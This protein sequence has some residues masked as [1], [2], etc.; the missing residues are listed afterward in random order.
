VAILY[1]PYL[2]LV[3]KWQASI[4]HPS[5]T[6]SLREVF[7]PRHYAQ[8]VYRFAGG[9]FI[10]LLATATVVCA[11][12]RK[13]KLIWLSLALFFGQ[14]AFVHAFLHGRTAFNLRY[15]MPAFP[16]FCLWLALGAE[17]LL[18]RAERMAW[19]VMPAVLLA[20]DVLVA[21]SFVTGLRE[22]TPRLKWRKLYTAVEELPGKK[23]VFFDVGWVGQPFAY[24]ARKDPHVVP[25]LEQ[26]RGWFTG[27]SPLDRAYVEE[28][29]SRMKAD[30]NCFLYVITIERAE[31][32]GPYPSA[33]VPAMKDLSYREALHLEH[34]DDGGDSWDVH[35]FCKVVSAQ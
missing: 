31:A 29:I 18:S 30:T 28:N 11:V 7:N 9:A 1:L 21:P 5:L 32:E 22:P 14:V 13:E 6:G 15:L 27:G 33:F 35:G 24:I 17:Q 23:A 12:L 19:P 3:V 20:T 10:A 2:I 8:A 4:G 34:P 25:L 26:G 16:M